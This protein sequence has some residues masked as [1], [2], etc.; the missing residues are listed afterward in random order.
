MWN[1]KSVMKCF[2]RNQNNP[3]FWIGDCN[4]LQINVRHVEHYLKVFV[5]IHGNAINFRVQNSCRCSVCKTGFKCKT[6]RNFEVLSISIY[7]H[8]LLGVV[9]VLQLS[10]RE[11]VLSVVK[12]R[13]RYNS[14]ALTHR[15]VCALFFSQH[16]LPI[17]LQVTTQSRQM[18]AGHRHIRGL[19]LVKDLV[20]P[21]R[22]SASGFG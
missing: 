6:S 9:D 15:R 10:E 11:R 12:Q 14:L 17:F 16:K 1:W 4:L 8:S 22:P 21:L 2:S 18:T 13:R 20:Q 7:Y 3:F 5:L 19:R